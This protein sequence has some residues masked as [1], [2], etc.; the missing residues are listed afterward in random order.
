ARPRAAA[1]HER[2]QVVLL[3]TT[4]TVESEIGQRA[5]QA[6]TGGR[7]QSVGTIAK[8]GK[9]G[10][11][12]RRHPPTESTKTAKLGRCIEGHEQ[13]VGPDRKWRCRSELAAPQLPSL[14]RYEVARDHADRSRSLARAAGVLERGMAAELEF[15]IGGHDRTIWQ[16]VIHGRAVV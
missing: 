1:Q 9:E 8:F 14:S 3:L 10:E 4:E 12:V 11:N 6:G 16:R 5:D 7:L 15:E 13:R 2:A